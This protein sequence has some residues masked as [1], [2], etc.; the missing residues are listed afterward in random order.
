MSGPIRS[1]IMSSRPVSARG[2]ARSRG[3][4]GPGS[5][6]IGGSKPGFRP[7]GSVGA[8][9]ATVART[10]YVPLRTRRVPGP[11]HRCTAAVR[12]GC[13][14]VAD[15]KSRLPI[16]ETPACH[17]PAHGRWRRRAGAD[18]RSEGSADLER[19]L[20][21]LEGAGVDR[22][23]GAASSPDVD[24]RGAAGR[25]RRP[26]PP[27]C[28]QPAGS[29]P[30]A[31]APPAGPDPINPPAAIAS[32]PPPMPTTKPTPSAWV[33]PGPAQPSRPR[34]GSSP[35]T[36]RDLEARLDWTCPCVGRRARPCARDDLSDEPGVQPR[37]DRT[38][39][40][41]PDRRRRRHRRARPGG[42]LHGTPE[43]PARPRV[44]AGRSAPSSRSASSVR[45]ACTSSFRSVS[46]SPSRS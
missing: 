37:L 43:P 19:R 23:P 2:H 39:A 7:Q 14:R 6:R 38:G 29:L 17:T 3:R 45:H 42:A 30:A 36:F 46:G 1:G 32:G 28:P 20:L 24:R 9:L 35:A 44:D 27:R 34:A 22:R 40:A 41:G 11:G 12:P 18:H 13:E 4:I 10:G 5:A 33:L 15:I 21:E 8:T 26:K 25:R 31:P 16:V